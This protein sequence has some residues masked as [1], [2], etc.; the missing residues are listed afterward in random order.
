MSKKSA[1]SKVTQ[2]STAE[3]PRASAAELDRLHAAMQSDVDTSEIPARGLIP[4]SPKH[5]AG[6]V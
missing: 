3:I 2:K 6:P 1:A 5:L 4:V